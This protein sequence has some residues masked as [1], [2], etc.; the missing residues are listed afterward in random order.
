MI[1]LRLRCASTIIAGSL[2]HTL[3]QF[4]AGKGLYNAV[5]GSFLYQR[6]S[7]PFVLRNGIVLWLQP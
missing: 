4:I 2:L 7:L 5:T 1:P 3:A 6:V